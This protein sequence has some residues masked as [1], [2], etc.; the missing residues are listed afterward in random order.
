MA[1]L[2][3]LFIL[4][5]IIIFN[6]FFFAHPHKLEPV[7]LAYLI[8]EDDTSWLKTRI[9]MPK[10]DFQALVT[11]NME[12]DLDKKSRQIKNICKKFFQNSSKVK[13][14]D[15]DV[16]PIINDIKPVSMAETV[17][18]DSEEM[19]G[20]F[21]VEDIEGIEISIYYPIKSVPKRVA[22][23][24]T[25]QDI[26][27]LMHQAW[28]EPDPA[29]EEEMVEEEEE[30]DEGITRD[31]RLIY[32]GFEFG[33]DYVQ[34]QFTPQEPEHYW[35]ASLKKPEKA[36][37]TEQKSHV[38]RGFAITLSLVILTLALIVSLFFSY[39]NQYK[40]IVYVIGLSAYILFGLFASRFGPVVLYAPQ[41]NITQRKQA[42]K[43]FKNLHQNIYR[44]FD[45]KDESDIYDTLAKSVSGPILDTIYQDVYQSL[46]L[47]E[48]GGA[49]CIIDNVEIL[50]LVLD[51][52]RP[53]W[54]KTKFKIDCQWRVKGVVRHWGHLHER[55]N[56]YGAIYTV[57]KL[58][59]S[60][61]ITDTKIHSQIRVESDK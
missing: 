42:E 44:A 20:R 49:V 1:N 36:D 11:K 52:S 14:N 47:Q 4:F 51:T 23:A 54:M 21:G 32:A 17:Y 10:T 45:Y 30:P 16:I 39:K 19:M 55:I 35:N 6:S 22:I 25:N 41:P 34:M 9:V 24:W 40:K 43:L 3:F 31:F 33:R 61:K 60:W 27:E 29:E 13:I 5:F 2:R 7:Y 46:I 28:T 12:L 57:S 37:V 38:N 58:E 50:D 15:V 48:H 18:L 8:E 53:D 59:K 56:E 26:Y